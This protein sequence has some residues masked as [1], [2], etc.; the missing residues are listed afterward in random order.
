MKKIHTP[1]SSSMGAH[2]TSATTYQGSASSGRASMSTPFSLRTR[3]RSGSCGAKVLKPS[4]TSPRS[5]RYRPRMLCPWMVTSETCP[6]STACMNRV[7]LISGA[8]GCCLVTIDQS[9]SPIRRSSNHNPRLRETGFTDT[10]RRSRG[11]YHADFS[12]A[13][14]GPAGAFEHAPHPLPGALADGGARAPHHPGNPEDL[15][16]RFQQRHAGALLARHLRVHQDVLDL[17]GP[18]PLQMDAIA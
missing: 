13:M 2:C 5:A 6:S 12:W 3:T 4:P 17:A 14:H 8:R 7:K 9:N 10:S 11:A 16:S 1:I 15:A 18:D